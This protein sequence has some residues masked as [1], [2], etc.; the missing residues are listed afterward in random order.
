MG[1]R[2]PEFSPTASQANSTSWMA[3]RLGL[4]GEVALLPHDA[5]EADLLARIEAL[6]ARDD[7]DGT[8]ATRCAVT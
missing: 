7:V 1:T 8:A 6:N 2:M 3:E 4:R 5:G